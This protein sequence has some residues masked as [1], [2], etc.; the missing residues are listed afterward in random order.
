MDR[1][2]VVSECRQQAAHCRTRAATAS[3]AGVPALLLT[4]AEMCTKLAEETERV[5]RAKQTM[6]PRDKPKSRLE[7]L[8]AVVPRARQPNEVD[9][10]AGRIAHI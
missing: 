8:C 9:P 3:D 4:M 6:T 10:S 5:Q 2:A 1:L 7:V